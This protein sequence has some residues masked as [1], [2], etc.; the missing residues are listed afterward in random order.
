MARISEI[1]LALKEISLTRSRMSIVR[2]G[3]PSRSKG[4]MRTSSTSMARLS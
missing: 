4:L 1:K 3:V 2:V